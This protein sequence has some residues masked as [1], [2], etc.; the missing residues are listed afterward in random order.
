LV[1][2]FGWWAGAVVLGIT[3]G[4]ATAQPY[5]SKPIRMII[6]APPGGGVDTVGRTIALKLAEAVGQPVVADNRAGAGTMI[7]SELTAKAPP[8]GYTVLMV[9]NSHTINAVLIKNL[10]YDPVKDFSPV[11]QVA[12]APMLLL[13]H[14]SVPATSVR[15]LLQLAR[16]HPGELYYAS[17]G[18]GSITHLGGAL[19]ASMAKVNLVHVP[20]K[21]GIPGLMDLVGGHVQIM[22]NNLISS[23]SLVKSGR[24]RLLAVSGA[25]RLSALPQTPT[26]AESGV[27]GYE[28]G[29]WYGVMLPAQAPAEVVA[30][31][32]REVVKILKLPEIREKFAVEGSEAVGNTPQEFTELIR[33][34]IQKWSKLVPALGIKPD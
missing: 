25:K 13:V 3:A 29:S 19:F 1:F 21:G 8:D 22:F 15:E 32:H 28:T 33:S 2:N 12:A 30:Y 31:L 23:A 20:Y 24:L 17:A 16:R 10:R 9:T 7:G 18:N 14:P 5:P 27:P 6:P 4:A 34:E 26:I 11:T